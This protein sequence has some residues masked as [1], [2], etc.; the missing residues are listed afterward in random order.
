MPHNAAE[1]TVPERA[2]P[3]EALTG[4]A[5]DAASRAVLTGS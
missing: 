2:K 3:P 4:A 1:T 5:I